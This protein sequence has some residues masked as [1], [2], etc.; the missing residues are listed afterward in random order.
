MPAQTDLVA[1]IPLLS[2]PMAMQTFPFKHLH[3]H[4][5]NTVYLSPLACVEPHSVTLAVGKSVGL[6]KRGFPSRAA[7]VGQ[8]EGTRASRSNTLHTTVAVKAHC[9]LRILLPLA[10]TYLRLPAGS[11]AAYAATLIASRQGLSR[12]PAAVTSLSPTPARCGGR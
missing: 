10:I 12:S 5:R 4:S 11:R 1:F 7:M 6:S 2:L 8:L 9:I 3:I